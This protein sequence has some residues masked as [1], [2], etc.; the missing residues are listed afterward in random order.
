[1]KLGKLKALIKH[2]LFTVK[3]AIPWIFSIAASIGV[4]LTGYFSAKAAPGAK[5]DVE[6]NQT[7]E[8]KETL[9]GRVVS[10]VK[11]G[12]RHFVKA[13]AVG[14]LTITLIIA[15]TAI[16]GKRTAAA[17]ATA[18]Y[19]AWNRDILENYISEK[20]S[21]EDLKQVRESIDKVYV[22]T[23]CKAGPSVEE[24][25]R[26]DQLCFETYFN[27]WFRS[28]EVDVIRGL[29]DFAKRINRNIPSAYNGL[30]E[31]WGLSCSDVAERFGYPGNSKRYNKP[32]S[33]TCEIVEG[34]KPE[35][36][37]EEINESVLVIDIY[38]PPMEGW[39]TT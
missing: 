22:R 35:G 31:N 19:L 37:D 30:Y 18:S 15:S 6:K 13:I 16:S 26:G 11:Y 17:V 39:L 8:D 24:T 36:S 3:K 2:G 14:A 5:E 12:W 20:L 33:Y 28:S 9:G 25:G 10:S 27:R 38:T 1:M 32:F 23:V 21:P 7:K 29:E 4:V 34:W